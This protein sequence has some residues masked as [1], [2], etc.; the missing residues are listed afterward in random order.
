MKS[1]LKLIRIQ[2]LIMIALMQFIFKYGCL[3][4]RNVP[5]ALNHWQFALLVLATVLI[6]AGG[7]IINNI[8]DQDTD[9]INRPSSV[10]AGKVISESTA[11][12]IYAAL[13]IAGV[14]IGFYLSNLIQKPGFSAIFIVISATLY[15]YATSFKRSFLI[16]NIL[17]AAI[18]SMSVIIVG[19]FELYPMTAHAITPEEQGTFAMY[20]EIFLDYALF[21][22]L[23][24]L[25]REITK[26]A[27]DIEGDTAMG[28]NTLPIVLGLKMTRKILF[29]M[30]LI[31]V[32]GLLYYINIYY[33]SNSLYAISAYMLVLVAGPLVYFM[34]KAFP[35]ATA[36]DFHLLSNVL[37]LVLFFGILSI[38][39]LNINIR[40]A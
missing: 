24:N 10:I 16:G 35:A 30:T 27:E 6:A 3:D 19:I 33:I 13:N 7:Y 31:M 32:L 38:L 34:L 4:M 39:L 22:F 26:D 29:T 21:S 28:M 23:I 37:K 20:F 40:Y 1:F 14:G 15:L 18:A 36:K 11:Y 9:H 5:T 8:V 2:N 25:I 12:N 17:V